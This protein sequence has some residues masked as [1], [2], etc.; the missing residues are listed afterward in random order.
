MTKVIGFFLFKNVNKKA[1]S[2]KYTVK[3]NSL[4]SKSSNFKNL[5]D[6]YIEMSSFT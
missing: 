6:L 3:I 1:E 5:Y 2:L 4:F